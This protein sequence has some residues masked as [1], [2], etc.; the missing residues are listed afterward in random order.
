MFINTHTMLRRDIRRRHFK[1]IKLGRDLK[2]RPGIR[3]IC[4]QVLNIGNDFTY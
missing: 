3:C 1:Q 4:M 2:K